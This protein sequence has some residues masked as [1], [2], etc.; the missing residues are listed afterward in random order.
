MIVV[1]VVVVVPSGS[2]CSSGSVGSGGVA[3][4][5]IGLYENKSYL[6]PFTQFT[7]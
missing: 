5:E 2:S 1:V 3:S 4:H 6:L 7:P